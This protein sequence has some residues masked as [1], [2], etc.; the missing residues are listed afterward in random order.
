MIRNIEVLAELEPHAPKILS[1]VDRNRLL[2][3]N[4]HDPS[5]LGKN[6]ATAEYLARVGGDDYVVS[7]ADSQMTPNSAG[8]VLHNPTTQEIYATNDEPSKKWIKRNQRMHP[9]TSRFRPLFEG[10]VSVAPRDAYDIYQSHDEMLSHGMIG[11]TLR[12]GQNAILHTTGNMPDD[13][14]F[15][16]RAVQAVNL[17][18]PINRKTGFTTH[19]QNKH[20]EIHRPIINRMNHLI[21]RD[22]LSPTDSFARYA[23]QYAEEDDISASIARILLLDSRLEPAVKYP[24]R[25]ATYTLGEGSHVLIT[26]LGDNK[27][28]S[29]SVIHEY[30]EDGKQ[31]RRRFDQPWGFPNMIVAD[32]PSKSST[33]HD[34]TERLFALTDSDAL[35]LNS[36][37]MSLA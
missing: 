29:F 18:N 1:V 17:D 36:L 30:V 16:M 37:L 35:D 19:E 15:F 22:G 31:V 4:F 25:T 32:A 24:V 21:K 5:F 3:S 20:I 7:V 28:H 2:P 11:Y 23:D 8:S 26:K 27:R 34:H 14:N 13:P 12:R 6:Y 9:V 33:N 10:H